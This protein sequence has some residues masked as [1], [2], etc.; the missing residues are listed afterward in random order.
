LPLFLCLDLKII[1]IANLR[2]FWYIYL[3][4][5]DFQ[6]LINILV[7]NFTKRFDIRTII[8]KSFV[9]VFKP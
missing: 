3:L 7:A 1:K 2:L 6:P 9:S 5:F 8:A 4:K